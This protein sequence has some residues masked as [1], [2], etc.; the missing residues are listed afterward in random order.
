[1]PSWVAGL[2][3][4]QPIPYL[5]D[6]LPFSGTASL[7][8]FFSIQRPCLKAGCS[9]RVRVRGELTH[10]SLDCGPAPSSSP[11]PR[12]SPRTDMA[13]RSAPL[14]MGGGGCESGEAWCPAPFPLGSLHCLICETRLLMAA[15][16]Q[17]SEDE[18]GRYLQH[19]PA[20]RISQDV[21]MVIG[22]GLQPSN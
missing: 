9:Q 18:M 12:E 6:P 19:Q 5:Q 8:I 4:N 21:I 16:S 15:T 22:Q 13:V 1:M 2:T 3:W 14:L 17:G 20:H 10:S 11:G 7:C